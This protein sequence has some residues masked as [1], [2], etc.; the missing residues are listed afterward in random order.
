MEHDPPRAGQS[1]AWDTASPDG[2]PQTSFA[3][4]HVPG[5]LGE[6]D[7]L[8]RRGA[9]FWRQRRRR[10]RV[11]DRASRDSS[12]HSSISYRAPPGLSLSR[13]SA[14]RR[15]CSCTAGHC[16]ALGCSKMPVKSGEG[17][18]LGR[19]QKSGHAA[20]ACFESVQLLRIALEP[21][22]PKRCHHRILLEPWR[23]S[24]RSLRGVRPGL[25]LPIA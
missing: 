21:S 16:S 2:L 24:A 3:D 6:V 11:L 13:L 20:H 22:C 5:Q 14:K 17:R 19:G 8:G 12:L 9:L 10:A 4:R 15:G 7:E 23:S 1:D 18:V 25:W